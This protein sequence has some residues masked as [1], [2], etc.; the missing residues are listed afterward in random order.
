MNKIVYHGSSIGDIKELVANYSTHQKKCIY[1]TDNI[2]VA[3]LFT[4][5][6]NK[7]LDTVKLYDNEIPIIVERRPGIF[8]EL[9]NRPGYIYELDGSTFNHHDYLWEPEVI[10]FE[11]SIKPLNVIYYENIMDAMY[12]EEKNNRMIIYKYPNRPTNIP[13]DNSDLIDEYISFEKQGIKGA[14]DKLIE[15]YPEFTDIVK[16]RL[17]EKRN[18]K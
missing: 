18:F 8:N 13:L 1:A 15:V 11:E 9:Y 2:G 7:D 5:R 10:S 16:E 6:G 14:I 4:A 12:E 17:N 3:M